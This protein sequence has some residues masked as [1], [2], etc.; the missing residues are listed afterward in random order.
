ML[1]D[2]LEDMSQS[3]NAS[4][5]SGASPSSRILSSK[6]HPTND[7][8]SNTNNNESTRLHQEFVELQSRYE[9]TQTRLEDAY[10][11]NH[12]LSEL[13]QQEQDEKYMLHDEVTTLREQL[14]LQQKQSGGIATKSSVSIK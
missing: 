13:V 5:V 7:I 14:I 12:T 1:H 2:A 3:L 8:N 9:V 6:H 4:H 11:E 10:H